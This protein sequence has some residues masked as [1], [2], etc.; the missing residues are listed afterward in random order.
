M[1]AGAIL[2]EVI[3]AAE[4][5]EADFGVGADVWSVTSFAELR[6]DA[7][8]VQR[9]SR[10]HPDS[11]KRISWLD[12]CLGGVDGPIVAASDYVRSV[13]DLIAPWVPGRYLSLGTDGFGRSDTRIALR[14]FFEVDRDSIVISALSSLADD[15]RIERVLVSEA[16]R[17][18]GY[19]PG[20]ANPWDI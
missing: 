13:A 19:Q 8:G 3:A 18:L 4:L 2:R 12:R 10:L 17:K 16:M 14:K 11:E 1:G 7:M 6:R 9:W 20:E 5:L 15:G